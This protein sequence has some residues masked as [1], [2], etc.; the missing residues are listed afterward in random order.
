MMT[1]RWR[2]MG[3]QMGP[4]LPR[5]QQRPTGKKDGGTGHPGGLVGWSVESYMVSCFIWFARVV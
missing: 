1:L 5:H 4:A 2:Q 3:R